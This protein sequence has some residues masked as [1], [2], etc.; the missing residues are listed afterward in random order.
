MLKRKNDIYQ[1]EVLQLAAFCGTVISAVT[2]KL[3]ELV[4][5]RLRIPST[6]DF[7]QTA[8]KQLVQR[9]LFKNFN[10]LLG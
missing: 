8:V 7:L 3:N 5:P 9:K 10:K 2:S 6:D 1:V 4:T